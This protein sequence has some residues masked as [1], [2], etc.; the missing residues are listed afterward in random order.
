MLD[1]W[2]R[3]ETSSTRASILEKWGRLQGLQQHQ[4]LLKYMSVIKEWPG[5]GS[6]LFDVECKE[7][8]FPHDLWLGVSAENISVYKWR[9]QASGDLPLRA[10]HLLWRATA[11]HLQDH[12]RWTRDVLRHASGGRDHQD[13]K[14]LHQHDSQE[15]LQCTL[16]IQLWQQLDQVI[17][18]GQSAYC[19]SKVLIEGPPSPEHQAL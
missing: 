3:E 1:M 9:G 10:H 18:T 19:F 17:R 15:A 12:R 5:Y 14:G 6:T 7:G 11:Q 2:L 13:H 16:R 8:G 4:A